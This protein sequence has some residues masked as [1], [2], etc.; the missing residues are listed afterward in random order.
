[1]RERREG[2]SSRSAT[3]QAFTLVELLVVIAIIAVIISI[4]LPALAKARQAAL[5]A[6]C[7][8]TIRQINLAMHMYTGD[9]QGH[10]PLC[11][12]G[13][14][15]SFQ[16]V[17]WSNNSGTTS[18]VTLTYKINGVQN[19][20]PNGLGLLLKGKYITAEGLFSPDVL[21]TNGMSNYLLIRQPSSSNHYIVTAVN[22]SPPWNGTTCCDFAL[23]YECGSPTIAQF[24]SG[25]GYGRVAAGRRTPYWIADSYPAFTTN[26]DY[27][28]TPH[29]GA[30]TYPVTQG[31][32]LSPKIMHLG[33]TD[34]S[35]VTITDPYLRLLQAGQTGAYPPFN[36]RADW[37]FWRY[38]GTDQGMD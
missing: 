38:F 34:G 36:D 10:M 23:G 7:L 20:Y 27:A 22:D 5:N 24:L 31:N 6:S 8:S 11:A 21:I 15:G 33:A 13:P 4:L 25:E 26:V 14:T 28:G 30:G 19:K 3:H 32:K 12:F 29:P 2:N 37:N 17:A 35:A 16:G 1:M 9:N 18:C